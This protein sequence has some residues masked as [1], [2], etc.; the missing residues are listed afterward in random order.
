M[1]QGKN[2]SCCGTCT[3]IT[4]AELHIQIGSIFSGPEPKA[5]VHYC[6]HAWSVVSPSSLNFHI[7]HS[8]SQNAERN[9]INLTG[10]KISTSSYKFVF[11]GP[12]EK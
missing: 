2:C 11:F 3:T 7:L 5:K 9:L 6:D 10:S 8:S 1:S 4:V 12:I